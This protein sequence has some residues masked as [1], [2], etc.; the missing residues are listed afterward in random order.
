MLGEV[1]AHYG[2]TRPFCDA[3]YFETEHHR[4]I[5]QELAAAIRRGGLIAFCGI[6]GCGKTT[7]LARLREA[8]QQ[9][10]E[11]LISRSLAVDKAHVNLKT[12]IMALFY[13]LTLEE[14]VKVPAQ[15]E[16]RERQLLSLIEQRGRPVVLFI[17]DAHDVNNQ[18][19]VQLKRLIELVRG[20]GETLSVVLAGHPKLKND[21]GNPRLEEI[22]ARSTVFELDG[23]HGEQETYIRWLLAQC[24]TDEA[25]SLISD[26]A[27]ALLAER[28]ATPLQIER[29]L[30]LAFEQ[31]HEIAEKPVSAGLVDS[32]LAPGL[33]DLEPRL[34]RHGYNASILAQELDIRQAEIRAFLRGT[35]P[36]GRTE[37]IHKQLLATGIPA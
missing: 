1:M 29:Y 6:V 20:A 18:T 25:E 11:I 22:G 16:R 23:I 27:I 19:L 34:A 14:A 36:P 8:L 32:V 21:M 4:R 10:G 28:L 9:E 5:A 13:D 12:L 31:A 24:A 33:D 30:T 17:D 37:E 2:I 7:L 35:L 3:G 26:A 15:A